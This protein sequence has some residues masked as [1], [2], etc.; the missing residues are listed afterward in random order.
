MY[1]NKS[2]F[3]LTFSILILALPLGV[4]AVDTDQESDPGAPTSC[5][6]VGELAKIMHMVAQESDDSAQFLENSAEVISWLEEAFKKERNFYMAQAIAYNRSV[7]QARDDFDR[8]NAPI[9]R[10]A[11]VAV[12]TAWEWRGKPEAEFFLHIISICNGY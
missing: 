3:V 6:D 1:L 9:R 10:S 7:A 11:Y 5:S 12:T 8:Q 2:T 4:S